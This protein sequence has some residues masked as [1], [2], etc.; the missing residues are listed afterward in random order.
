MKQVTFKEIKALRSEFQ[1][2]QLEKKRKLTW[3]NNWIEKLTDLL[4]QHN[5][6]VEEKIRL[7]IFGDRF[8][9]VYDQRY[10]L[11]QL[12]EWVDLCRWRRHWTYADY[13]SHSLIVNNID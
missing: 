3:F 6:F 11:E 1:N 10:E 8:N 9:N 7:G 12:I 2:A 5:E 13:N 4:A